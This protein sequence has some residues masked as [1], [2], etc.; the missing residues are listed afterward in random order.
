MGERILIEADYSDDELAAYLRIVDRQYRRGG[1]L[2]A[3]GV[4]ATGF[5]VALIGAFAAFGAGATPGRSVD[6]VAVL[7]LAG[8][9]VGLWSPSIWYWR[10]RRKLM[11]QRA[12]KATILVTAN[13]LFVR[14]PGARGLYSRRAIAS[15][16]LEGGLLVV[17]MRD[18]RPLAIPSRLLTP[19]QKARLAALAT[20]NA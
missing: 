7:I 14:R 13:G 10:R 1:D 9:F 17:W 8:F 5:L 18:G 2:P 12:R 20:A 6:V 3:W 16:T 19:A 4:Y 15:V 11:R